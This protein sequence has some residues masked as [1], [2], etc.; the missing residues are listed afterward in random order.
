MIS[1]APPFWWKK[2]GIMS[3]SLSPLAGI[4]GFWAR[5][6]LIG[7]QAPQINLP[8][9]CIGNFTL[10]GNGK[11]PVTLAL[12]K[13]ALARGLQPGIVSRGSG[14]TTKRGIHLVDAAHDRARDVGDEPLLLARHAPVIVGVD[15]LLAAKKLQELGCNIILMDDGFQSRRLYPDFALLV[16]D[17]SRGIGNGK[18]FPAG[19]LRAPIRTQLTHTDALLIFGKGD[20]SDTIIRLAARSA[21][22]ISFANLIPS[23]SH[24]VA[25]KKFL[26]FAGIGNPQRFFQTV[27][28]MGG[29]LIEKRIFADHHFFSH[30]ELQ[31]LATSANTQKLWLAT[32]AKD[33][34]RITTSL[35]MPILKKLVVFD[36]EP[37]F[38]EVDYLNRILQQTEM[39]FRERKLQ[40]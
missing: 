7:I 24:K 30:H 1:E 26:A 28:S 31:E 9:L 40:S 38:V 18:V 25:K 14:G 36:I 11:T 15:R 10:G 34:I 5:R 20:A 8:V 6:R 12:A 22:P 3:L 13:A 32:T 4:Y 21:K 27:E 23:A 19:P 39:R 37:D 2:P 29:K 35:N 33:H 17:A 16:V